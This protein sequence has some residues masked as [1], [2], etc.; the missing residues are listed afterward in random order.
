MTESD[1]KYQTKTHWVL[2]VKYGHEVYK[3][4]A[5]HSTRCAIIGRFPDSLERAII[6]CDKRH[7]N[8]IK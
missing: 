4:G 1:I 6:E 2:K 3:T 8:T 5:T 7:A